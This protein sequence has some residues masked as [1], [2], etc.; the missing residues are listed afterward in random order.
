MN[1]INFIIRMFTYA[2]TYRELNYYNFDHFHLKNLKKVVLIKKLMRTL[3]LFFYS[4]LRK[5]F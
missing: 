3:L 5:W 1:E 2:I 4:F